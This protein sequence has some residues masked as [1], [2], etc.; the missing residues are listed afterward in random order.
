M[1]SGVIGA[2]ASGII[3][4]IAGVLLGVEL[5]DETNDTTLIIV[6][7]GVF[8]LGCF[9]LVVTVDYLANKYYGKNDG[10]LHAVENNIEQVEEK[11][12][13][14]EII[15]YKIKFKNGQYLIVTPTEEETE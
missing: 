10:A 12:V 2:I 15:E 13:D 14:N 9:L 6:R 7:T 3:L 1:I 4:L 5:M 8:F 11:K